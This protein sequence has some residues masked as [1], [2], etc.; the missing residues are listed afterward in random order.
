[1]VKKSLAKLHIILSAYLR[2]LQQYNGLLNS[3]N[4]SLKTT[5]HHQ[6]LLFHLIPPIHT[7]RLR[8]ASSTSLNVRRTRLTTVGDRTFPVA[9][10]RLW[11]SLPS[12]VTAAPSLS[13]FCCHLKSHLF[14]LS[15]PAFWLFSHLYTFHSVT[16]H[17]GHYNRLTSN[18]QTRHINALIIIIRIIKHL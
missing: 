1:M 6:T 16:C 5:C 8:S 13:I 10:A 11:N 12:H 4:Q 17:F 3:F 18:W 2:N 15:Y 7:I 14:S 9:A